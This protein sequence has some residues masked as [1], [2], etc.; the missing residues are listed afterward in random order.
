MA[1][2]AETV[3]VGDLLRPLLNSATLNF[4]GIATALTDQMVMVSFAA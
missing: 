2:L 1:H 3:L 4:N